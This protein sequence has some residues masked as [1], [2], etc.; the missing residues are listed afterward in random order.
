MANLAMRDMKERTIEV[1]RKKLV[2]TLKENRKKHV[3]DYQVSISG[4]RVMAIEKLKSGYEAAKVKLEKNLKKGI[5][6]LE[7][8][9]PANPSAASDY[10]TLVEGIQ[11]SL[12][13]PRSYANEYDTAIDMA[14]W[15]VRD[16]L[17]LTHA[18]FQCFVRDEWTWTTD[19]LVTNST[20][21]ATGQRAGGLTASWA[22]GL[23]IKPSLGE[24]PE[25]SE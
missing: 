13:V 25:E 4:Y 21:R 6:S 5:A 20:Y 11:V 8:F 16:T 24:S 1:D 15:D 22:E 23:G 14:E 18:E 17:E 19:F 12:K 3:E 9:D 7:E 10:L 2:A